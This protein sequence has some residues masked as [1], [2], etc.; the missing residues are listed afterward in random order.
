[1]ISL[2]HFF[3]LLGDPSNDAV[4]V[5][6]QNQRQNGLEFDFCEGEF[7]SKFGAV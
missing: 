3:T 7:C 5:L 2:I 4:S 1:M 6:L